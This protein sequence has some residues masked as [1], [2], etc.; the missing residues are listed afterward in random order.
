[1]P[2]RLH[3]FAA[4]SLDERT[5]SRALDA[6]ARGTVPRLTRFWTYY[7][8]PML[9]GGPS[10][11]GSRAYRLA[12]EAG[13]P[14]RLVG[15]Q[16]PG[17]PRREIVIE[18]DIAWRVQAMVD[19]LLGKPVRFRSTAPD[20]GRRAR[21]EAVLDRVFERSGGIALLQDMALLGHVFGHVDLMVRVDEARLATTPRPTTDAEALD[22]AACV[23]VEVIEPRRGFAILDPGDYR[24]VRAYVIRW[25]PEAPAASGGGLL[26]AIRAVT[27]RTPAPE[28]MEIITPEAWHVYEQGTLRAEPGTAFFGGE[29]PVVHIQNISQPFAYEGL[30]EV[31]PLI[32][33][34]D[35]LNTR[36]S[37]RASR[38]TL[39]SFKMYLARGIDGFD[40]GPVGP[41][42]VWSTDNPDARIDAF[43]GDGASPSEDAHIREVRDALDKASAVPPLASGVVQAKIGN[44][45][46]ATALRVTLMGALAKNDRKRVTYG[47]GLATV[48]RLILTA[49]DHADIFPTRPDERGVRLHWPDPLPV[50]ERDATAAAEAKV[51]L[52]VPTQRVLDDLGYSD[53]DAGVT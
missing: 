17:Q 47:R 44:L 38:V 18:N 49:L 33:L 23:R 50:E 30:G 43:G 14:P 45:S 5:L 41:G 37:D 35:E 15:P 20:A 1:M 19:L 40:K 11:E 7:R 8:N 13:L 28:V 32:P 53:Q 39:Q 2:L 36:L 34:Q 25:T 3:D 4:A 26:G 31:E 21:I 29:L 52:G 46:S 22:A 6:H 42:V 27:D 16:A 12:Q 51:R 48:A 9:P 24:R 10:G